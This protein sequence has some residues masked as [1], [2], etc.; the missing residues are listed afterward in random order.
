MGCFA[1]TLR[2]AVLA[3]MSA[4]LLAAGD[5]VV[6]MAIA[7]FANFESDP[8]RP[9]LLSPDGAVLYALNTPDH[10]LEIYTTDPT[11]MQPPSYVASVFT[12][13]DPVSMALHP[14]NAGRLFVVN[15]LSDSVSVVDLARLQVVATIDVGD[16]PAD[17]V[18]AAGKLFVTTARSSSGSSLLSPGPFVDNAVVVVQADAP[19]AVLDRIEVEGHRPRSLAVSG[20]QV[21]VVPLNSGNHTTAL[22]VQQALDL[23]FAPLDMDFLED[24]FLFNPAFLTPG[25]SNVPFALNIFQVNGWLP[26]VSSRIFFDWE[27]GAAF[28]PQLPDNDMFVIDAASATLLPTVAHGVGT[29]LLALAARPGTDELW[30]AG[31]DADNRTRFERRLTGRSVENRITV[32]GTDGTVRT[33]HPLAPPHTT[34]QHA[35]PA[36]LAF[37][38][39]PTGDLAFVGS[40]GSSRVLVLDADTLAEVAEIPT[41]MLPLGLAVDEDAGL[42]YILSRGAKNISAHL[43]ASGFPRVER[44]VD[45]A[46]DPEP[47][48]VNRGRRLMYD[49]RTETGVG[50]GNSSCATCHIFGDDDQLAWDLGD[51]EGGLGWFYTDTMGTAAEGLPVA[52]PTINMTHPLKGAMTTQTLRGLTSPQGKANPLHWRGDRRFVQQ[53]RGAFVGLL[54]GTGIT[55]AEMQELAAFVRTLASPPNPFQDRDRLYRGSA[56][57]GLGLFG[58]HPDVQPLGIKEDQPDLFCINCHE[59]NLLDQTDFSGTRTDLLFTQT[60]N[61]STGMLRNLYEKEYRH[62]T[63]FGLLHDGTSGN[64]VDFMNIVLAQGDGFSNFNAQQRTDTVQF[65]RRWDTGTA[66]MLGAQFSAAQSSVAGLS[67]WLDLAEEQAR[68]PYSSIDLIA[69]AT[70]LN[71]VQPFRPVGIHYRLDT[72]SGTWAWSSD[73]G[74]FVERS[75]LESAI[76]LG[77]AE[78]TFTCVPRHTGHRLGVD[79]DEDDVLDGIESIEGLDPANPDSDE[80]GYDDGLERLLGSNPLVADASLPADTTAPQIGVIKVRDVFVTTASVRVVTDEPSAIALT[81]LDDNDVLVGTFSSNNLRRAHDLI[82]KDLPADT[83]LSVFATAQD[84]NGNTGFG[85]TTLLTQ[86]PMFH[87]ENI[88]LEVI[89]DGPLTVL[90]KVTVHDHLGR[91]LADVPVR[92]LWTGLTG[93]DWFPERRTNAFGI[94]VFT[95]PFFRPEAQAV[96]TF[97][98]AYIGSVDPLDPWFVGMGGERPTFFYDQPSNTVNFKSVLVLP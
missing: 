39:T 65:L 71:G 31:T 37:A 60:Q 96:V 44:P 1:V 90:A 15:K 35:Q 59:G 34:R 81:V 84:R 40:L 23:S 21:F 5:E 52:D 6:S 79:R 14:G 22:S 7:P 58:L 51:P 73:V 27:L 80:D 48:A 42:L 20:G 9:L 38:S 85:Q 32:V 98:P 29:T 24:P 25:L 30:V 45:F 33:I 50:N 74:V 49:A 61:L 76:G 11:G 75:A 92:G 2:A 70:I 17:V 95:V 83:D 93:V 3:C 68:P 94:A 77:Q 56:L 41:P 72:G 64:L 8:V 18:V 47:V 57:A 91:A 67:P 46:Y 53:F 63:G 13:L 26:P 36:A 4:S 43:I 12:G 16:E 62:L 87:V 86:P 10:R 82:L 78:I 28:A 97:S 19:Y 89:G 55:A 54:G 69:K 66:P 88:T